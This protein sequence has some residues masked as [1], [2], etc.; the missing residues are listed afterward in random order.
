MVGKSYM[1]AMER[2]VMVPREQ[3]II[4]GGKTLAPVE[5]GSCHNLCV[6]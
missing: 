1:V 6:R 2:L 3:L 4:R 5:A